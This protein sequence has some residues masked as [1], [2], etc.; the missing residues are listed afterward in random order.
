MRFSRVLGYAV[1]VSLLG[2]LTACGSVFYPDRR[3]QIDGR[4]DPLIAGLDALGLLFYI[5]PGVI[6]LGVDFT[7]GA[8]YF[9]N[10]R[11]GLSPQSL[12]ESVGM[13]GQ[14]DLLRLK[15]VLERETGLRVPLDDPHLQQQVGH[16]DQLADYGLI[17][18]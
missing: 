11:Y 14:I 7:T 10:T 18:G 8:I 15:A 4:I 16:R 3:G 12:Q 5:V 1:L 2:Q 9:P 13:D 17:S 6:A